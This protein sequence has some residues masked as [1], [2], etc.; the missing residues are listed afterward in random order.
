MSEPFGLRALITRERLLPVTSPLPG[1]GHAA[2]IPAH[3]GMGRASADRPERN[4]LLSVRAVES[5]MKEEKIENYD[6]RGDQITRMLL[7]VTIVTRKIGA[8]T[9]HKV[10][11]RFTVDEVHDQS[12]MR[13]T[14]SPSGTNLSHQQEFT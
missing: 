11:K 10:V 3:E 1:Y 2:F 6:C 14:T 9:H 13:L 12:Q 8:H 7:N 4:G 5:C